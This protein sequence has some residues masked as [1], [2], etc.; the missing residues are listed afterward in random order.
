MVV[1]RP[2]D[3]RDVDDA[4]FLP[5]LLEDEEGVED[6]GVDFLGSRRAVR[7]HRDDANGVAFDRRHRE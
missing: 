3:P 7:G 1:L 2:Q 5:P 6:R 4:A